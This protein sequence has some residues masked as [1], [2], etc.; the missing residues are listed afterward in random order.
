ML[1]SKLLIDSDSKEYWRET[2]HSKTNIVVEIVVV[3]IR[4]TGIL[5][6]VDPRAAAQWFV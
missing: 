4:R 1:I 2:N 6:I 3:A 5:R